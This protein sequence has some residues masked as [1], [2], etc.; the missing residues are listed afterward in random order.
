MNECVKIMKRLHCAMTNS[1]GIESDGSFGNDEP[2]ISLQQTELA[3]VGEEV[4][5]AS[6]KNNTSTNLSNHTL[7]K[8]KDKA[9][10]CFTFRRMDR[11]I[12]WTGCRL[13]VVRPRPLHRGI[14]IAFAEKN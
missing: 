11:P 2:K 9:N 6:Q 10:I 13:I 7:F 4:S 8:S 5:Q 3:T 12:A 14:V 1:H